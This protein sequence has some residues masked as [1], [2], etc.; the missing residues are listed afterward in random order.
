[1]RERMEEYGIY[2]SVLLA[3]S[4]SRGTSDVVG[5]EQGITNVRVKKVADVFHV[6]SLRQ[7]R[8]VLTL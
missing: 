1:M 3:M 4:G 7:I 6:P 8:P 2:E 5:G